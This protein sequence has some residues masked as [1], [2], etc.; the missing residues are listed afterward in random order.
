MLR[1]G[2]K[3]AKV[4]GECLRISPIAFAPPLQPW[5]SL[6]WLSSEM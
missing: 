5:L 6:A 1:A 4:M 3:I 2:E